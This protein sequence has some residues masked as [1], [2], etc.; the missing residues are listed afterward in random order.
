MRAALHGFFDEHRVRD[1]ARIDANVATY[2]AAR[3]HGGALLP[4][5]DVHRRITK[6]TR[7]EPLARR[8]TRCCSTIRSS[9]T[10]HTAPDGQ[11]VIAVAPGPAM[12]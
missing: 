7:V 4:P 2:R 8:Y 11:A 12:L 1:R 3:G 9:A 5:D 10:S 6:L